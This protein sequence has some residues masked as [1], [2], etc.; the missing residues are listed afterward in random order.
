MRVKEKMRESY[1]ADVA[2]NYRLLTTYAVK[3]CTRLFF[4]S[5]NLTEPQKGG[6]ALSLTLMQAK[7]ALQAEN[8]EIW[9]TAL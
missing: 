1:M 8:E 7:H 2:A 3:Q 5:H 6:S 4:S 9:N